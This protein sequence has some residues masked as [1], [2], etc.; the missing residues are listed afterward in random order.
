MNPFDEETIDQRNTMKE[1]RHWTREELE[2][3][4]SH[5]IEEWKKER[6]LLQKRWERPQIDIWKDI[7]ET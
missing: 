1:H 2:Q 4:Y 7:T 3:G 5:A 6:E